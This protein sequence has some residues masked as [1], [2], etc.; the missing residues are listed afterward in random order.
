[1]GRF[2]H[3]LIG[4]VEAAINVSGA[5]VGKDTYPWRINDAG[6]ITGN[7][8]DSNDLTHGFIRSPQGA[9]TAFDAQGQGTSAQCI[10]NF[11]VVS[12]IVDGLGFFAFTITP[13]GRSGIA[14]S[15]LFEWSIRAV[16]AICCHPFSHLGILLS[17]I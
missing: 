5:A 15:R 12:G 8:V 10:N 16:T 11:G 13:G 14:V 6:A 1:M 3:G 7:Y 17:S 9:L 2:E 4:D